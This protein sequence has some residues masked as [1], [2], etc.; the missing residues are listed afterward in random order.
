MSEGAARALAYVNCRGAHL[1][2]AVDLVYGSDPLD[3]ISDSDQC[4]RGKGF[5]FDHAPHTGSC[6]TGALRL[7]ST[8]SLATSA[9]NYCMQPG[10]YCH[11]RQLPVLDTSYTRRCAMQFAQA[12]EG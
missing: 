8:C 7:D 3:L 6:C 4:R 10:N 5:R 1:R 9:G 11:C 12:K 2:R